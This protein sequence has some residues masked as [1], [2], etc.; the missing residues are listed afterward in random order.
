ML[1]DRGAGNGSRSAD[2]GDRGGDDGGLRRTVGRAR[3]G[4]GQTHG[5]LDEPRHR[6]LA[7]R[8]WAWRLHR[9]D[10]VDRPGAGS[11]RDLSQQPRASRRQRRASIRWPARSARSPPRRLEHM[12]PCAD[13]AR[14]G[15]AR[16]TVLCG[17]DVLQRDNFRLL[18]GKRVGL[19]T[20][21]TGVN[22]DGVTTARLLS[23]APEVELRG[24]VQPG[25]RHPRQAGC[26][27][28][29]ATA[30]TTTRVSRSGVCTATR[31]SRRAASLEG[32]DTLVFDIQ[33]IGT[34]FYT[35]ISTLGYAMQAAAEA[36]IEFRGAGP[37]ESDQRRG[38]GRSG[39]GPGSRVVCGLSCAC[40]CATA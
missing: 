10:V 31:A 14:S 13:W 5:L 12:Q 26:A 21:H 29:S 18:A 33:D 38:R 37:A 8:V 9:H 15:A 22:R 27:A 24:A 16:A 23:T 36:R 11:V 2:A 3:A 25:A 40:P 6:V 35:Y 32:I 20:N 1:L 39:A 34:R 17:I 30:R 4:L 28:R 19:I 7:A